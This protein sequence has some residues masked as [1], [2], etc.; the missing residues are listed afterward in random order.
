MEEPLSTLRSPQRSL[1]YKIEN[2]KFSKETPRSARVIA[3]A[4][5]KGGV[6]KTN[7]AVNL[8]LCLA[9]K[10]RKVVLIDTDLGTANIDVIMNVQSPCDLSHVIR[11]ERTLK[12]AAV[13]VEPRLHLVVGASGLTGIADL[14]TTQRQSLVD[15]LMQL[16]IQSDIILLDC[17]AGISQNVLAFA[18][19]AD[20]LMIVTT[21]EP[22]ALTDAYALIKVLCLAHRAPPMGL[23]VNQAA[24]E[25]EGLI[26]SER[27]AGVASKFLHVPLARCG[28]ILRDP[29]VSKA[30]RQ[31][32]PFIT[33]YP[34]CPASDCITMLANRVSSNAEVLAGRSGFFHRLTR[35]FY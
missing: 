35:F 16:E 7:I 33:L 12:E 15:Q 34:R 21:P 9:R 32:I 1:Q 25:R 23:I 18:R 2:A 10:G 8:A 27:V 31:R 22:T 13:R 4:S 6:G 26:V 20:E 19:A 5:G 24:T 30:V 17:G 3:I 14:T 28:Q 11:R 29:H